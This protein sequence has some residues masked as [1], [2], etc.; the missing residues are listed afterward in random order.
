[1][2]LGFQFYPKKTIFYADGK[3]QKNQLTE[4]IDH[5][6]GVA[7]AYA[8][9][10]NTQFGYEIALVPK[11]KLGQ[12]LT[13]YI[14]HQMLW[15]KNQATPP[16]LFEIQQQIADFTGLKAYG[17]VGCLTADEWYYLANNPQSP[18]LYGQYWKR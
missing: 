4:H 15:N 6:C 7:I 8:M 16:E 18:D 11:N 3:I 13:V 1:M 5:F 2:C 10:S 9:R 14:D 17:M 12:A